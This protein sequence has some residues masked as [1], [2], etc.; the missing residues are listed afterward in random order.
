MLI[1]ALL[2]DPWMV[3]LTVNFVTC[4]DKPDIFPFTLIN[5]RLEAPASIY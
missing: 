4:I 1:K 2:K 5:D 3:C